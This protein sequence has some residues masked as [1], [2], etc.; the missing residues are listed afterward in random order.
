MAAF[1]VKGST[2]HSMFSL[3]LNQFG[4]CVP[5]LSDDKCNSMANLLRNCKLLII[6]EV[7][8]VSNKQLYAIS[9]RLQQI[10]K[11]QKYFGGISV[12]LCGG[13]CILELIFKTKLSQ[14]MKYSSIYL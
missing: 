10:F 5:K 2:L 4:G 6:D 11:N 12:I 1:N 9:T 13:R 14:N 3:P 7:S 8:M